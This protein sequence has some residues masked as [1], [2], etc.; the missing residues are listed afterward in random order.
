VEDYDNSWEKEHFK[1][2]LI[3]EDSVVK[4][5]VREY[6]GEKHV[7]LRSTGWVRNVDAW[8]KKQP[9]LEPGGSKT[10]CSL[11]EDKE[12]VFVPYYLRANRSGNSH[13]RVGLLK[14]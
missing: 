4:E 1:N 13:M 5:E 14:R 8:S 10:S 11:S 3:S 6:E 7:G 9:G 2:V 12:L